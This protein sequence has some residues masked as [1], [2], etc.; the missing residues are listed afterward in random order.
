MLGAVETSA[1]VT[2]CDALEG[3]PP[4]G[5]SG[6]V[7]DALFVS[8]GIMVEACNVEACPAHTVRV[9]AWGRCNARCDGGVATRAVWCTKTSASDSD[10]EAMLEAGPSYT[11]PPFSSTSAVCHRAVT[12][13]CHSRLSL[14]VV[15]AGH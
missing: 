2:A 8:A 5:A 13:G 10:D 11:T 15:T 4:V 12:P 9:G 14:P 6:G 1:P 3:Y 7:P